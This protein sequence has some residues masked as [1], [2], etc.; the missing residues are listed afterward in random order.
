MSNPSAVLPVDAAM[1]RILWCDNANLIRGKA[2]RVDTLPASD[3]DPPFVTISEAMQALPVM[4]DAPV[5][6]TGLGPIGAIDLAADLSSLVRLPY[7]RGHWSAMGDMTKRG[8]PWACCP[9]AFLKRMVAQAQ[10]AGLEIHAAFENEFYLLNGLNTLE[11]SDHTNFA[12]A[13]AM[14][15]NEAMIDDFIDTLGEQGVTVEQYYP[16]SGP[17]QQ[18]VTVRYNTALRAC[19][20]QV[21]FR[22]TARAIARSHGLIASFLPKVFADSTGNGCHLHLSLWRDDVNILPDRQATHGLSS[23][24]RHFIAGILHHLPALMAITTPTVNSYRRIEPSGWSGA[25]QCWGVENKEAAVRAILDRGHKIRH[26]EL[27]TIDATS[28]PYLALGAVIAA[29]LDGIRRE[30]ELDK[31]VQVDPGQLS[32]QDREALGIE[33]LPTQLQDA[34]THLKRD[35]AIIASLGKE[36]ARAYLGVKKAE[37][38]ALEAMTLDQERELLL[39]KY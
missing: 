6:S 12:A 26:F 17:G 15:I 9:R 38:E 31:P 18:E 16:E 1:L 2:V 19:D 3:D 27:K 30:L 34:L 20:Q 28:N 4:K 14:N 25:F 13:L 29:G 22:E 37:N 33:P 32:N 39:E 10:E 23:A 7:T 36:L 21:I 8:E 5:L 11:P 35:G 24:A